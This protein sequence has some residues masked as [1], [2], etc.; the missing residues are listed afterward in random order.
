[1]DC[2]REVPLANADSM[3]TEEPSSS[4]DFSLF[5]HFLSSCTPAVSPLGVGFTGPRLSPFSVRLR[6][7]SS[8][9]LLWNAGCLRIG[10][11][12]CAVT[13]LLRAGPAR[14]ELV[15]VDRRD[16][17]LLRD[18]EGFWIPDLERLERCVASTLPDLERCAPLHSSS[19]PL[20]V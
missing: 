5:R 16:P 11:S 18:P 2:R 13:L 15:L 9:A 14:T 8:V 7:T 6:R 10:L 20:L 4:C 1:M 12:T 3:A 19:I 17:L